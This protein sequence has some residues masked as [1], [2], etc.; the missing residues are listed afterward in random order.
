MRYTALLWCGSQKQGGGAGEELVVV[1]DEAAGRE[2]WALD[3]GVA[4]WWHT[5]QAVSRHSMT[6]RM[7]LRV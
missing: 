3:D 6:L 5:R 1:L 4:E 7:D 2:R